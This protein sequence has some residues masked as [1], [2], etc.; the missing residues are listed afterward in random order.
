[1]EKKVTIT[2]SKTPA[3]FAATCGMPEKKWKMYSLPRKNSN[4]QQL[5]VRLDG[6]PEFTIFASKALN[7]LFVKDGKIVIPE[8][9]PAMKFC[10]LTDNETGESY[11][12]LCLDNDKATELSVSL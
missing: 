2:R 12:L 8:T 6:D 10:E 11:W 9:L 7:Q 3:A 1:M 4:E 5:A